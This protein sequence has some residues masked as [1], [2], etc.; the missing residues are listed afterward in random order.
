MELPVKSSSLSLLG[1]A[2]SKCSILP[3]KTVPSSS[4]KA[5]QPCSGIRNVTNAKPL[6]FL[7]KESIG[8]LNSDKGPEKG[9]KLKVLKM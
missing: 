7:V 1:R 5:L 4:L 2:G 3:A 8:K 9:Y 6:G